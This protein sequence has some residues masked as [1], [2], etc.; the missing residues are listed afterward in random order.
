MVTVEGDEAG[1]NELALESGIDVCLD[2]VEESV[3]SLGGRAE[4]KGTKEKAIELVALSS[5]PDSENPR[6]KLV[7]EIKEDES[8][9]HLRKLADEERV[10]RVVYSSDTY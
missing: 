5:N 8:L 10:G 9:A 4:S 1:K 7:N 3:G 6:D 2:L